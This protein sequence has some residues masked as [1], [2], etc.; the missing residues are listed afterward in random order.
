M[1][2]EPMFAARR[3]YERR[4]TEHGTLQRRALG[5]IVIGLAFVAMGSAN[6]DLFDVTVGLIGVAAGG[7]WRLCLT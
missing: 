1:V 4:L 7:A 6:L 2:N 5:L 3:A